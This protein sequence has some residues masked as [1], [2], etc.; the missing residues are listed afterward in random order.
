MRHPHDHTVYA[1]SARLVDD[2]FESRDEHLTALQTKTLLRR[3]LSG[4][5]ILK[6]GQKNNRQVIG[7]LLK[8]FNSEIWLIHLATIQ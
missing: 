6:P 2:G 1:G 4:Q 7:V 3:P 8:D 5:E